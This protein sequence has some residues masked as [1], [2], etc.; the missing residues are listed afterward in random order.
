[1]RTITAIA[2]VTSFV[3]SASA[4]TLAQQPDFSGSW[5][6]NEKL[7]QDPFDKIYQAMGTEQLQGAGTRAYNSV[8]SSTLLRDTDRADTLRSLLDFAEVLDIVEIDHSSDEL[9]IWVGQGEEFFSLFYLDGEKHTRQLPA[10]A[11]IE[12]SASWEG[13]SIQVLQVGEN[14]AVLKQIY[15][16]AGDDQLAFVFVLESKLSERPVQFR[17]VYDRAAEN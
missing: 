3:A 13:D 11:R 15:S 12:A 16:P 10:G 9:K 8:S 2:V 14:N 7:S 1:M 5:V 17:V 6:L 4:T